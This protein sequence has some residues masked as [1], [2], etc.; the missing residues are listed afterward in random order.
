MDNW[1]QLHEPIKEAVRNRTDLSQSK[2]K[3]KSILTDCDLQAYILR[4]NRWLDILQFHY[5]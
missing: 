1:K 2:T 5:S 4:A 3:A